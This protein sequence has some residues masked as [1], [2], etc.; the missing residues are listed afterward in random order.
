V[1]GRAIEQH[2][3]GAARTLLAADVGAGQSEIVAQEIRE[4]TSRLHLAG[5]A[6]TIVAQAGGLRG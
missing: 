6:A 1:H 3:A 5:E 2:R 4:M